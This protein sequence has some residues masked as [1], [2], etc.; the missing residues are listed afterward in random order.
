MR[1][2][3]DLQGAQGD[4]RH[5]GIG[6]YSLSL[7]QAMVRNRGN[8]EIIIALNG[9]F[10]DTI[11]PIRAV[12]DGLLPQ[13]NIRVWQ[14]AGPVH[15]LDPAN[16]WRRNTAELIREA[17]LV[18]LQPDILHITSLFEGY[19]DDAVHSIGLAPTSIPT[20]ITL[21]DLIPLMQSDIYLKPNPTYEK[22]YKD[23]LAYLRQADLYFAI[24]ESSR[25]ES[26]DY[27]NATPEQ[28]V[29]IA[30]AAD[31]YF[32][33]T[34]ITAVEKQ[35]I[36]KT[37]GLTRRFVMYSGATDERKNH[38]RLI[39]AFSLLSSE[40]RKNLQLAIVGK[41]P[42]EHQEKFNAYAK[43]CGLESTDVVITGRVSDKEMVSLYNLCDLFV[44][45]SWHEG[46][47]L[48]ALEAMSCGA[49]VIGAN[50][51]SLPEVIG[52]AD[53]LFDPFDEKSISQKMAEV[54]TNENLRDDL[55]RH[56]L[57]QSKK[58]S[59]DESAKRAIAAFE[60]W[61]SKQERKSNFGSGE[62][63]DPLWASWLIE[64]VA[65]LGDGPLDENDW[66]KTAEALAQNH[67]QSTQKQLL[68]DVSELAQRDAKSGVQRVVRSVLAE[69]L[70]NPP[71]GFRV[72]P[73]YATQNEPGY[74]YARKFT[75]Q[76]LGHL[77]QEVDDTPVEA[78]NGDI[79]FG[80]DLQH[81]V[82]INNENYY[83]NLRRNGVRVY[84]LVHDLLPV[85]MP[86]FFHEGM[87]P[88]HAK[89][90]STLEKTDGVV[91]VSRTVA[92]ELA[93][94]LTFFGSKRLRPFL[95]GWS[96]N[97]A[98][99]AG[100]VPTKGLPAD[101]THVFSSLSRRATFLMVGT[102]EPRKGQM[103]T[104]LA[105]EQLWAQ[106]VDINLVMVGKYGWNVDLLVEILRTHSE[107]N[108]R[109]FWLAGISDEY[110]EKV[111]ASSSCLIS[112]SEGEGF[113]LPLIE[114]AQNKLPI[115]TRDI[116]VFRE[117]AGP[118]AFY[119]SGLEP[120][121]LATAV[122]EWLVIDKANQAPQSNLM[123]W[124]T[125]KESTKNLLDVILGGQWYLRWMPDEVHRFW[126][127]DDRLGTQVGK[128]T[129]R[130]IE[131]TGQAGHLI[132]GPYMP[133]PAG[134]YRVTI[135]GVLGKNGVAGAY[136]DSAVD[137]GRLILAKSALGEPD[138]DGCLVSLPI[139]LDAPC[140][141]LEIRVWVSNETDV[142]I[143]KLTIE[144]WQSSWA[145]YFSG[146]DSRLR[147][148]I[149]K[150]T[151]QYIVSTG[152]AGH[153]LFGPYIPLPA[154]QYQVTIRG[155]LGETGAAGARMD[156]AVD[157]GHQVLGVCAVGAPNQDGCLVSLLISLDAP[158]TD[159]EV[160]IWVSEDTDLKVSMISIESWRAYKDSDDA[161]PKITATVGD[162]L[163]QDFLLT[164]AEV[165]FKH[166]EASN[167]DSTSEIL[168][169][170]SA[171]KNYF[172]P[173]FTER[174]QA[175]AKRKKKR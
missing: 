1:I 101:A 66:I 37:F 133:L 87:S 55:V 64:K 91:C 172:L 56:G 76:F 126:G 3:I 99:L 26:I 62:Q 75:R 51:S 92:D 156:V 122:R 80:L 15:P 116:P 19:G 115:I 148:Q 131:S 27:L 16:T 165:L 89:W 5:R 84:F 111:Y 39:K 28:A 83:Q 173:S 79:F 130:D 86:R 166:S 160:R 106:G 164:A 52:R 171:V 6:R 129:G 59:W 119:F 139:T 13:E 46:F 151:G 127:G 145:Y 157:K 170:T 44:F 100:S 128:R 154:G 147:T 31:D 169:M 159:L 85:L 9:M 45:P 141:D 132:Y 162:S 140:T 30:A 49:P 158:C 23:K 105:F 167:E 71:Q 120:E 81:H 63:S 50:T 12:F 137:Q 24:S 118:H 103:Q 67:A 8:H 78:F 2:V 163:D 68:V 143:S 102:I 17:F 4:S 117:V 174:N 121:A 40:I 60:L 110:L 108:R 93:E 57:E 113:G 109:L 32:K 144:P 175:K 97:A 34:H 42:K 123:P 43:L 61:Y 70:T 58:F 146:G 149:G 74:S 73:V 47:G 18:N 134:Q 11:E 104:L 150:R 29:N 94:W 69:L 7:A 41:L 77:Q 36:Y 20:A 25:Q 125:W 98:D 138:V 155:L 54:L 35:S 10:P 48:P 161:V 21:Y 95:I 142:Q 136:I 107:Y 65:K 168:P 22:F 90:L 152:E 153:L 124:L 72:E 38:L 114:A 33:V 82:V 96:H 14:A 53:A 135:S 88:I 112:A